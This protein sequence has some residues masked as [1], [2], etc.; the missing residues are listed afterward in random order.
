M[1]L[2]LDTLD[3]TKGQELRVRFEYP[4]MFLFG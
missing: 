1:E 4:Q 2:G 3:Y